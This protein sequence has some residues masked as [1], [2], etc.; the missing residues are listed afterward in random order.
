MTLQYLRYQFLTINAVDVDS[1]LS[2]TTKKTC[3]RTY[4]S[5][6]WYPAKA[7][8]YILSVFEIEQIVNSLK[9]KISVNA[10]DTAVPQLRKQVINWQAVLSNYRQHNSDTTA[11]MSMETT[12]LQ[13]MVS[14]YKSWTNSPSAD[15]AYSALLDK[16]IRDYNN[17]H[18][19]KLASY[20]AFIVR[21]DQSVKSIQSICSQ[22]QYS[23]NSFIQGNCGDFSEEAGLSSFY[24][25]VVSACDIP[26]L[27]VSTATTLSGLPSVQQ[28]CLGKDG[29]RNAVT[30]TGD[31][32]KGLLNSNGKDSLLK[33]LSDNSK[34]ITFGSNSP[35]TM[36]WTSTVMD[37]ISNTY[38]VDTVGDASQ[39]TG[40]TYGGSFLI[41]Y[42][43]G[44][45][46]GTH[47]VGGENSYGKTTEGTHEFDR[48]VTVTLDDD[49]IG[50]YWPS[51]YNYIFI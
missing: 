4:S 3:L 43:Q 47:G 45:A 24:S 37:Y 21:V 14:A 19:P 23:S 27:S 15:G 35:L 51:Y 17:Y 9:S 34:L 42:Y 31:L 18:T 10:T 25:A 36:S 8:T 11:L 16:S 12:L 40:A 38:Y 49:D 41:E 26:D 39:D 29:S 44:S 50:M 48:T 6:V 2:S 28:L 1:G 30:N 20:G 22:S 5:N 7:T 46:L 33:F 13:R 32:P